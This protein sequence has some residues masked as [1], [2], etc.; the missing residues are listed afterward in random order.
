MLMLDE[1]WGSNFLPVVFFL[2]VSF[3]FLDCGGSSVS[4]FAGDGMMPFDMRTSLDR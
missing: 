2:D 1:G 3:L 4:I